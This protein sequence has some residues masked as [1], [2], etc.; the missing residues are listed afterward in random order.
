MSESQSRTQRF[1]GR[2]L[3][4]REDD[5]L[6]S[7][8]AR[9]GTNRTG[10]AICTVTGATVALDEVHFFV[11][12]RKPTRSSTRPPEFDHL[13]VRDGALGELDEWLQDG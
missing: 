5:W 3:P 1:R 13:V 10:S 4:D 12:L 6:V 7:T 8:V 9:R 11:T 2:S